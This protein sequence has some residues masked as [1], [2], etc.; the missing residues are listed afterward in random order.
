MH[1]LTL[2]AARALSWSK[3]RRT[4]DYQSLHSGAVIEREAAL[5]PAEKAFYRLIANLVSEG[6]VLGDGSERIIA[7]FEVA[8]EAQK[9]TPA[10]TGA[11]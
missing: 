11:N 4:E 8:L 3:P 9:K 10:E 2:K 6:K 5:T 1:S 7:A